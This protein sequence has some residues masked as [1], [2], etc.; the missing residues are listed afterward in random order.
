I[1]PSLVHESRVTFYIL[2]AS[3]PLVL[4]HNSLR[5]VLE[6]CQRFDVVNLLRIP[7]SVLVFVIPAIAIPLGLQLP[8]I[9]ASLLASRLFFIAAHLFYCFRVI[10]S[11]RTGPMFNG[12]ILSRLLA[13]GGWVT[14]GN[15]VNPILVSMER[16]LIGSL[17]SVAM[18]GY[19]TA[20]FEAL[21]KLWLIPN[22]LTIT[23]F[24]ACSALG[25]MRRRELSLL[26]FRSLKYL[27]L[28]LAPTSLVGVIFGREI[29]ALWLG[30]AFAAKSSIVFQILA[31]GVP[32]NCFAHIPYCFL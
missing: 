8:G 2:A 1:P 32:I 20:S 7:S 31:I 10:P 16:F 29:L 15:I 19:Y 27:F 9:V 5:A 12:H 11:M 14:V 3:L 13:Y 28:V 4:V 30:S 18:V 23:I 25:V 6:G 21:T 26:Y 22:S 24:P 17:I